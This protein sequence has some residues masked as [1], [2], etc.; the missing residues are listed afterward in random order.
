MKTL[1][2]ICTLAFLT[3]CTNV[4]PRGEPPV[5]FYD[6]AKTA[7]DLAG[8]IVQSLSARMGMGHR[9]DTISPGR[10]FEVHPQKEIMVGGEPYFGTIRV[11]EQ[12]SRA[13]LQAY[14]GF[15][16]ALKGAVVACR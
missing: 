8:C 13:E 11:M 7:D 9:I 6:S 10:I 15:K 16:S 4:S 2:I 5:V 3:G 1:F 14:G 12:G